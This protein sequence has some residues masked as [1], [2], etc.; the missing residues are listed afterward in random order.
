MVIG[1]GVSAQARYVVTLEQQGPDVVANGSGSLD[2]TGLTFESSA[3]NITIAISPSA[4][5][6]VIGPT[7]MT[8]NAADQ[9]FGLFGPTSFGSGGFTVA[10]SGSRDIVGEVFGTLYVPE[11][12]VSDN[13]LSSSATWDSATLNS[14][15]LTP[16]SYEWTWGTGPNQNLTLD[17]IAAAVPEPSA[18]SVLGVGLA[19]LA[20]AAV[21]RR[22][23]Q[24]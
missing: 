11:G 8:G 17:I 9:Y 2:L 4:G 22:R 10:T 12:Y 1:L 13:P 3:S 19:G 21:R 7:P 18:L 6:M 20:S 15:G 24:I 16:G 5:T 14:L 23:R